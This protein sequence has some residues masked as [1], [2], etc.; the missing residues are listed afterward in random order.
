MNE[1]KSRNRNRVSRYH[2]AQER[3]DAQK[4]ADQRFYNA[5]FGVIGAC[6][7]VVLGL[8]LIASTGNAPEIGGASGALTQETTLGLTGIEII[9]L[10]IVA[11]IG[12]F[13]WRRI[14]RR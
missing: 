13:M 8:A 10:L 14:K 7:L 3:R 2:R 4:R 9:G 11:I 6:I 1:P 5:I 12:F